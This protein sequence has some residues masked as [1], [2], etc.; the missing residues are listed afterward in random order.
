MSYFAATRGLERIGIPDDDARI[1][2]DGCGH[3]R[4]VMSPR[5]KGPPN[6][7]LE[8][9]SPPGWAGGTVEEGT[10]WDR[11]PECRKG[12]NVEAE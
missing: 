12:S 3:V 5:T 6:W 4:Y 10:R 11:C 7:L 9:K 8:G 2:C 1:V